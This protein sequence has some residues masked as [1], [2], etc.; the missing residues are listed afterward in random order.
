[1]TDSKDQKRVLALDVRPRSFGYVLF[2]GPERLLDW[3]AR[4]FRKGVNAVRIPLAQKIEALVDE[5][6]PT[7]VVVK[8]APRRKKINSAKRRKMLDVI[9]RKAEQ[10]GIPMRV[11]SR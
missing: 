8:E 5:C 1:M 11:L 7:V 2:E 9:T 4:S 3:G 10:R 6:D